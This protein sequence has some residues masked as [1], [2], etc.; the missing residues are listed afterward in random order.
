MCLLTRKQ[1]A[2]LAQPDNILDFEVDEYFVK[3]NIRGELRNIAC[4]ANGVRLEKRL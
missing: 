2:N 1:K 3:K 4:S